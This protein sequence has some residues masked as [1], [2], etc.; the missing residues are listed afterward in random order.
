MVSGVAGAAA[1]PY[2]A[3]AALLV[4]AGIGKLRNP[5]AVTPALRALRAPDREGLVRLLAVAE[6]LLGAYALVS[7][8][9]VAAGA[10][11]VCYGTFAGGLA[12]LLLRGHKEISCGCF[13]VEATPVG[14]L[15]V[16][17]N[18]AFGV[19][20][21]IAAATDP[22]RLQSVADLSPAVAVGLVAAVG[23]IAYSAFLVLSRL[24]LLFRLIATSALTIERRR[25]AG[26][27]PHA[28]SG[29]G[30]VVLPANSRPVKE[31][32]R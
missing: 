26:A 16:A 22:G 2:L 6:I 32:T 13:G 27:A 23:A 31:V 30:L 18:V 19:A 9:A 25:G 7:G 14:W 28:G 24:S 20:C 8:R 4:A 3:A 29:S 21:T 5:S 10:V 15:H 11:A 17:V 1:G 12:V